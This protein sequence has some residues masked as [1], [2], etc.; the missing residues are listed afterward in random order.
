MPRQYRIVGEK[1][2]SKKIFAGNKG[3]K[4]LGINEFPSH[5]SFFIPNTLKYTKLS[6][7]AMLYITYYFQTIIYEMGKFLPVGT[8][9]WVSLTGSHQQPDCSVTS[10]SRRPRNQL[11]VFQPLAAQAPVHTGETGKEQV[12][13]TSICVLNYY[14]SAS[15]NLRSQEH[16]WL[17]KAT[18][19]KAIQL[20][21]KSR[22]VTKIYQLNDTHLT[23]SSLLQTC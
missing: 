6:V 13:N 19:R 9:A 11:G 15:T 7:M 12:R 20:S 23:I 10:S 2:G 17:M 5:L 14:G 22:E 8:G 3:E 1:S 16:K 18:R 4:N 21:Q